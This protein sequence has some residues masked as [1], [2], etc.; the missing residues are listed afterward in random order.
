MARFGSWVAPTVV[1]RSPSDLGGADGDR[2]GRQVRPHGRVEEVEA[3]DDALAFEVGV[4]IEPVVDR[5]A[6]LSGRAP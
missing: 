2:R 1:A 5:E 4:A 6:D 3:A